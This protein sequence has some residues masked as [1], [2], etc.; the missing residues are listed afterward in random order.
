MITLAQCHI[1]LHSNA[2]YVRYGRFSTILANIPKS[3][4]ILS[5]HG[6]CVTDFRLVIQQVRNIGLESLD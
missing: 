5:V 2:I 3:P 6:F 1:L 4:S